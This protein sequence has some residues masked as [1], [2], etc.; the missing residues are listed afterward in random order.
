MKR[1][2][3][4]TDT[5][6]PGMMANKTA[7]YEMACALASLKEIDRVEFYYLVSS[8]STKGKKDNLIH[9][10]IFIPF[11]NDENGSRILK[12]YRKYFGNILV[13][14]AFT[15]IF[16]KK[17]I[18]KNDI[19]YVRGEKCLL[20]VTLMSFL[21]KFSFMVEIHNFTFGKNI[22]RN[23]FYKFCMSRAGLLITVSKY[24]KKSWIKSGMCGDKIMVLPS[25]VSKVFFRNIRNPDN[26]K[27]KY[28]GDQKER[29]VLFSGQLHFWEG[30]EIFLQAAQVLPF[31]KFFVLGGYL[32]D[33]EKYTFYCRQ[34]KIFN[35]Y[36]LGNVKHKRVYQYLQTADVLV[37][38]YVG[39][40]NRL[41]YHISPLKLG[42]YMASKRPIVASN[43]PSIKQFVTSG[44]VTFFKAGNSKDLATKINKILTR[45]YLYNRRTENAYQKAIKFTWDKRARIMLNKYCSNIE[46]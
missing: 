37:M 34:K 40:D 27:E 5:I 31:V 43:L 20:V 9:K 2:L 6:Y 18:Y 19:I 33:I 36:F 12:F 3:F 23:I 7:K 21:K 35:V 16:L 38:C 10:R 24:T 30:I 46:C 29:V 39:L 44:E 11:Y 25:G 1:V 42:E 22:I 17:K 41:K 13:V 8:R 32:K 45:P 4:F 26:L 28:Y 15:Y 14:I